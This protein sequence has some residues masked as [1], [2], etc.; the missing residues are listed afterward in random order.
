MVPLDPTS[1]IGAGKAL[2]NV[3]GNAMEDNPKDRDVLR[4]IAEESGELEP[5]ARAYAKR[6]A[7]KEQ[8][9]LKIWQP[10]GRLVGIQREYFEF[11]FAEDMA[12]RLEDV[13][14]E[15]LITPRGSLAGLA[16]Q[17]LGFTVEEPE[18]REMYLNLL[19]TASDK[20]VEKSAHPSFAEVIKQLTAEEA[21]TLAS[22]IGHPNIT[23]LPIVQIRV[24]SATPDNP[25]KEGYKVCANHVMN[26][27]EDDQPIAAPENAMFVDNWIRLGL[28]SVD[29]TAWLIGD[30]RYEWVQSTPLLVEAQ[31]K[32][33]AADFA[34]VTHKPGILTVT[35][36][37]LAFAR[38][39]IRPSQS[40]DGSEVATTP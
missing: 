6:L 36:F 8:I 39:V 9:W 31:K 25:D 27:H 26:W 21:Q 28:V 40:S 5:A 3:A 15:A 20:R 2:A 10:L 18:L 37:G 14:E 16:F 24:K 29:Y 35:D 1:A 11:Q 33:D 38:V 22:V 13:P 23:T 30:S 19:A 4:Q 34:R 17:G 7:V 32:Y 12:D